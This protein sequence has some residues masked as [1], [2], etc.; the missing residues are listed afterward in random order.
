MIQPPLCLKISEWASEGVMSLQL[1]WYLQFVPVIGSRELERKAAKVWIGFGGDQWDIPAG[2]RPMAAS[3]TPLQPTLGIAHGD[4]RLL[5][6]CSA[7]ETHFMK[8]LTNSYCVDVAPRGSLELGNECCNWG[9]FLRATH[10]GTRQSRSVSLCGLPVRGWAVVAPRHFHFTITALIVDWGCSYRA[11]ILRTDLLERWHPMTVLCWKSLR[12][13][14]R[15][16]YC[17]CL[18]MEI[19]WLCVQ[20][21]TPVCNGYGWN[22]W[23]H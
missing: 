4:L 19:A 23:I 16:F 18:S 1:Q 3:F 14:L 7:V 11:D 21:Y 6:G 12:S 22:S 10:F 15:L 8:I 20:L 13:S 2:A 9:R 5:C 17:Q